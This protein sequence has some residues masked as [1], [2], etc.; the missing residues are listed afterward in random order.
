VV[1]KNGESGLVAALPRKSFDHKQNY[2]ISFCFVQ[3]NLLAKQ[4]YLIYFCFVQ[5]IFP[6]FF[7]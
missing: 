5:K 3:K 4:N 6:T 1:N 7:P 2:L